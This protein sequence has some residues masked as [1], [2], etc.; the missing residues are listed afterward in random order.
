MRR[1]QSE[2][3]RPRCPIALLC[4]LG[5]LAIQFLC[6]SA[7]NAAELKNYKSNYYLILTNVEKKEVVAFGRH[8]DKVFAEYQRRFAGF[9]PRNTG[10]MPLYLF[11][12]QDQYIA[13][14]ARHG[15]SAQNSGGMFFIAPTAQGLATW[16]DGR[17]RSE[18]FEVLQHE[19][20]HQFAYNYFGA[21][22]PVW[23]NEG[24][25]QYFEDGIIVG[26]TMKLG[27]VNARRLA[28]VQ[29]AISDDRAVPFDELVGMSYERWGS[30][31]NHDPARAA[32]NYAQAW[33]VVYFLVHGD[34]EKYRN[35]FVRYLNLISKG[36]DSNAAFRAAFGISRTDPM[37]RRWLEFIRDQKPDPINA[38]KE[39]LAFLGAALGYMHEHGEPMPNS[40]DQLREYLQA[41]Q[42]RLTRSSHGMSTEYASLDPTMYEFTRSNGS[43]GTFELLAPVKA[44][45]PPR[46]TAP[47][48]RPRPTLVWSHDD[49]GSLVQDIEYR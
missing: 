9:R 8:M 35:A 40:L 31:L 2:R 16:I 44:N 11:R 27:L 25:A 3:F 26:D 13:F 17:S 37:A 7:A 5:A 1:I 30:T 20:F 47:G 45:L 28:V 24:M 46:I 6:L 18:T 43:I 21:S 23:V 22:L 10:P 38:A 4:A 14:M 12:T 41:R 33:N 42:F 39:K 49:D 29:S 48:L 34:G 19:G 15:L 36:E 32:L